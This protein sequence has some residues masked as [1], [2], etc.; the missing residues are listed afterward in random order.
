MC[1]VSTGLVPF[2]VYC[3][4]RAMNL[5]PKSDP[6]VFQDFRL[7]VRP[8]FV[9]MELATVTVG[10]LYLTIVQFP[11]L[12]APVSFS[13]WFLSMDLAPWFPQWGREGPYETRRQISLLFGL[14]LLGL[15]RLMEFYLGA[16]P[17]FGF[18][19]YLF[20]LITFWFALSTSPKTNSII[21]FSLYFLI[22]V[23]LVV[24]GSQLDRNTFKLFG[25]V[26][27]ILVAFEVLFNSLK[28]R[29][30]FVLWVLK[31]LAAAS[32]LAH[33]IKHQGSVELLDALAC[34]VAFNLESILYITSGEHYQLFILITDLGFAAC[35]SAFLSF[36]VDVYLFTFN[37]RVPVAFLLSL[38]VAM[39]HIPVVK[40]VMKSFPS[41]SAQYSLT[42]I[43]FLAWRVII[44]VVAS[45][46]IAALRL[47]Q[48]AFVGA[49]GIP[50]VSLS[51]VPRLARGRQILV[52]PLTGLTLL[53]LGVTFSQYL[54]SNLL[55]LAC[56][57]A[58][59]ALVSAVM[60]WGKKG[61]AV[62][63]FL[64]ALLIL[65]A[66]PL[67]SK[68]MLVIAVINIFFYLSFLAYSVFKNSLLFPI[69]LIFLG[70]GLIVVGVFYQYWE[71]TIYLSIVGVIP[72]DAQYL[73]QQSIY[74][75]N[76]D[77]YPHFS[78]AAFSWES[79]WRMPL[80]WLAWP[81]ALVH[82]LAQSAMLNAS[83]VCG[84]GILVLLVTGILLHALERHLNQVAPDLSSSVKV[85][86]CVATDVFQECNDMP[87]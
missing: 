2:T 66:I 35:A 57:L 11:F 49:L 71:E 32:L 78:S 69:V 29:K 86:V 58:M 34:Y 42:T 31:A 4:E 39:Y 38:P 72:I 65:S 56:I 75:L 81:G 17:D 43:I 47:P 22:N 3:F 5:W 52:L 77:W 45:F 40:E 87:W 20:G 13:L 53:V 85:S 24:V 61:E 73:G 25:T 76:L 46:V 9:A 33:A 67:Q 64:S 28:F 6:G 60:K 63:C 16:E 51:L 30:S 8:G 62:G 37:A 79:V 54:Q 7:F 70:M 23:A 14:G 36:P 44:S 80:V 1:A 15:G 21:S 41:R 82:A 50:I 12:L 83:L 84:A 10:L 19:L 18:W 26:G 55:Y 59:A 27:I 74:D 68:L 48:F